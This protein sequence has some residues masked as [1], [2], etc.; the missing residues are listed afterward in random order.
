MKCSSL[1]ANGSDFT[2][3]SASTGITQASG[4]SCSSGFDMDSIALKLSKPLPPGNYTISIKNGVDGN[5]LLDNCD[6]SIPAGNSLPLTILPLAPVPMDSLTTV[7]CA[8]QTLE[9]V[10]KKDIRCNSIAPDGSDFM[11]T[12]PFPV[13]VTGA[14]GNCTDGITKTITVSLSAP[15]VNA[16]TYQIKLKPG[17]DGNTIVDDCAQETPAGS[18]L[19]FS[20]KDTVSADFTYALLEG[21]KMTTFNFFHDGRNGVNQWAWHLDYNGNNSQQ[22]PVTHFNT[23]G[24]KQISLSVTNGFC[25]DTISKTIIIGNELKAAFETNNLL[26]PEDAATIINSSIGNIVSYQW[27]FGDGSNSM[28][29]D[30][31]P[32]NYPLLESEKIYAIRLIV[33]NNIGC[34]D[35]AFQSLKVLKSCYIAVPNAFTPNGD[36]LNDFLY[37]LNAYKAD[38]LEFKVY[39]RL[40]QLVFQTKDWTQKWDGTIQGEPQDSGTF[41]W[42]LKY[43]HHDSG[44]HISM[45]GSAVLIR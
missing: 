30:P 32:K 17:N 34:T 43:T 16:G 31:P 21:C 37:P 18:A 13:T 14:S 26:C 25:S 41:V 2:I 19:N 6:Q 1:A 28:I 22:N 8:P 24:A 23:Y 11:V 12:G 39:N 33:E 35:T 4:T 20:V 3:S 44:K 36:G 38:H 7:K 27:N 45:K 10:F 40:G 5:T 9:L 15:I 42:T 29:K